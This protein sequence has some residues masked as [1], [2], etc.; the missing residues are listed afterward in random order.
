MLEKLIKKLEHAPISTYKDKE[1]IAINIAI[2]QMQIKI[3]EKLQRQSSQYKKR[4]RA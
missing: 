1:N 4:Q 2:C 3:R